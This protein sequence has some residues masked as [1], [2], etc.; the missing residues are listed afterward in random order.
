M[1]KAIYARPGQKPVETTSEAEIATSSQEGQGALGVDLESPSD[2]ERGI[3]ERVFAFHK[4][5]IENCFAQSKHPRIADY[6]DYH[7]PTVHGVAAMRGSTVTEG[8]RVRLKEVDIF[9]GERVL[10]T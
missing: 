2:E 3:L 1:L 4:L 7:H 10:I 8:P 9:L 6:R 5:A